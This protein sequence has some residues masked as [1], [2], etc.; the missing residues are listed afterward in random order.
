MILVFA[1]S[2]TILLFNERLQ[3]QREKEMIGSDDQK[4]VHDA[5]S[6]IQKMYLNFGMF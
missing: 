5:A 1:T 6:K 4:Q 2:I 3:A